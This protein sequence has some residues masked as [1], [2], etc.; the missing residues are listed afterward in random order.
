MSTQRFITGL[1][2]SAQGITNIVHNLNAIKQAEPESDI[3]GVLEKTAY[4]ISQKRQAPP[5]RNWKVFEHLSS[6][7]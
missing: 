5:N 7:C 2:C 1:N 3:F 4:S 6:F